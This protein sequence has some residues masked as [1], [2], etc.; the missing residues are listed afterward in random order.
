M[1]STQAMG[2]AMKGVTKAMGHMNRQMNL[3]SLQ[4]ILQEFET[5]KDGS[6]CLVNLGVVWVKWHDL[7]EKELYCFLLVKIIFL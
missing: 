5:Q 6:N 1:K 2:E 3:S 4:K 7:D